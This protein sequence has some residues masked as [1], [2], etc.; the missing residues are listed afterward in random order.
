MGATPVRERR[1]ALRWV[2]TAAWAMAAGLTLLTAVRLLPRSEYGPGWAFLVG[3]IPLG[4]L[5]AGALVAWTIVRRK[6]RRVVA[7][8]CLLAATQITWAREPLMG[9]VRHREPARAR[10]IRVLSANIFFRNGRIGEVGR[11]LTEADADVVLLV[12]L[13]P[14]ALDA[15]DSGPFAQ[16][17]PYRRV[18]PRTG[19]DGIG[20]FSRWPLSDETIIPLDGAD[21]SPAVVAT[22]AAP[23]APTRVV[24]AHVPP[25]LGRPDLWNLG[26]RQLERQVPRSRTPTIWLGDFNAT[27]DHRPFARFVQLLHLA[28]AHDRSGAG[29]G[30]TWPAAGYRIAVPFMRLD[31]VLYDP[32]VTGLVGAAQERIPG[33]DHHLVFADLVVPP[34][35]ARPAGTRAGFVHSAG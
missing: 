7:M 23:G 18:V 20:L 5:P 28:D 14:T 16:N 35:A 2:D 19:T 21:G 24:G 1:D 4:L 26:F 9:L 32:R 30:G 29:F 3:L 31:H 11:A 25:P 8:A 15:L 10:T 22:V 27:R 6:S 33:S 12:E 34:G 13:T 17:Y